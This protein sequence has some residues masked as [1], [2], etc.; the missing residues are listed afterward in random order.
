MM[1]LLMMLLLLTMKMTWLSW[2][3]VVYADQAGNR[4]SAVYSG[5]VVP[6]T[7]DC[8]SAVYSRPPGDQTLN[9]RVWPSSKKDKKN[10]ASWPAQIVITSY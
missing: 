10:R 4:C 5:P 9:V 8:C 7:G 2:A 1:L 3:S 6:R